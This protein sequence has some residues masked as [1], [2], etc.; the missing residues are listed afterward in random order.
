MYVLVT[1]G[2]FTCKLYLII[3]IRQKSK[4][5]KLALCNDVDDDFPEDSRNKPF[6]VRHTHLSCINF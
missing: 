6:D 2:I 3:L 5:M 4:D 1:F